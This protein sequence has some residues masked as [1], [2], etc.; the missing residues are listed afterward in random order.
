M[1][2]TAH[3][4]RA[5]RAADTRSRDLDSGDHR[6]ALVAIDPSGNRSQPVEYK[7]D[8]DVAG[9][10]TQ[11]TAVPG[12]PTNSTS[13]SFRLSTEPGATLSCRVDGGGWEP[14]GPT[15]ER[16]NLPHGSHVFEAYAADTLGNAGPVVQ[17]RWEIDTML[18]VT[19]LDPGIGPAEGSRTDARSARFAFAANEPLRRFECSVDGGAF[20]PCAG[21]QEL[22]GLGLGAHSFRVQAVD[23]AGNTGPAAVRSWTVVAPPR[24]D[25]DRDGYS[26]PADCRDDDPRIHPGAYDIPGN[27]VDED[28]RFG[29]APAEPLGA[30]VRGEFATQHGRTRVLR[31]DALRVPAGTR[32]EVRSCRKARSGCST[33]V[34]SVAAARPRVALKRLAG[35]G[36]LRRGARLT[37]RMTRPL[38][39]GRAVT[40]TMRAGKLPRRVD[41]D[42]QP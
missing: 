15:Y 9:P 32:I 7:W 2:S 12:S 28:C 30:G 18:P 40:F 19:T 6:F 37:I 1:W 8:V 41:V 34:L 42:L 17:H 26:P 23:H 16:Y 13:A 14:C 21:T 39:I 31:L 3:R 5:T 29:P 4:S 24:P 38:S 11:L 36:S 35:R 10:A 22:T 25:R 33:R 20:R 27:D